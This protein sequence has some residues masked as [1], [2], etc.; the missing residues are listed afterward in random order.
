[1]KKVISASRRTD[2]VAYYPEWLAEVLRKEKAFVLAPGRQKVQEVDL[3]PESVHTIVLWSKN[4]SPL[5]KNQYGLKDL[6]KKYDQL[7]LHFTI[8]G[9]GGSFLE[10]MVPPAEKVLEQLGPLIELV[11]N[12]ARISVR[13][14]PI[15]FWYDDPSRTLRTNFCF[16][17][18]LAERMNRLGLITV[19]FSFVQ[20]YR[21]A[22]N[23]AR[24]MKLDYYEPAEEEKARLVQEMVSMARHYRLELWSC[25]QKEIARLPGI[26]PSS[27]ID[28]ALL[29]RLHPK[30]ELA[31]LAKDRTQR[32]DCLCTESVDIGSYTQTCPSACLY[33]YASP[34]IKLSDTEG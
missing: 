26:K 34:K 7:Y 4:F 1:M 10:R 17:P 15:I 27:C 16:F 14:D 31:S 20:W 25:S 28:G 12:P 18:K 33:C 3:R 6:L 8:T 22:K 5:L 13:F 24:K 11:E 32:P 29:S 23:R 9:L 21:K 30:Q 2:L 19:R